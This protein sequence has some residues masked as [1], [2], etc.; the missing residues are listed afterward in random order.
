MSADNR[1][2]DGLNADATA[3]PFSPPETRKMPRQP[4][5]PTDRAMARTPWG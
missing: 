2:R 3:S 1:E 5:E 4:D